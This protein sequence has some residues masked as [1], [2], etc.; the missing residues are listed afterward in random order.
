MGITS[1]AAADRARR[2]DAAP[3]TAVPGD[4]P[5]PR[6]WRLQGLRSRLALFSFL[7]VLVAGGGSAA[8]GWQIVDGLLQSETSDRLELASRTFG[9]LYQQRVSDAEIVTRQLSERTFLSQQILR[10]NS[11]QLTALIDPIHTL[12]P[13]YSITVADREGNV[14]AQI[15]PSSRMAPGPNLLDVPG[16]AAALELDAA[17]PVL[18]R[19]QDCQ[20]VVAVSVPAKTPQGTIVGLMHLRFP[21][22]D[23]FVNQV[24]TDTGLDLSLYCGDM[25]VAT[26]LPGQSTTLGT[27]ADP[28]VVQHVLDEGAEW[29]QNLRIGGHPYRTR[30]VPLLDVEG[31]PVAM[32]AVGIPVQSLQDARNAILRFYLPVMACIAALAMAVG[33]L[34][35]TLLARPLRRLT[36]AA[37]RIGSGDL[38]SPITVA[39]EDEVAQLAERMEE[40][41]RSLFQ[42]Y[43][44]LRQLNQ[45]KDEYLFSVA[46]EVRTPLAS[47]VASVEILAGDYERMSPTERGATIRRIERG[48]VRLQTLVEN[49]LDAGSIRAGRFTILPRAIDLSQVLDGAVASL[50]PLLEDKRQR[51][52]TDIPDDLPAVLADERRIAQVFANLIL[53]ASKYG[54]EGDRITVQGR[55][56]DGFVLVR[57]SDH[58]P[59]IP[60]PEQGELFERYFRAASSARTS[61]GTGLGLA[62]SKAIVEAHEG[63][64][65]LE[66]DPQQG[67]T[68]WFT[69]PVASHRESLDGPSLRSPVSSLAV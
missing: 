54:P 21:L 36:S 61:P 16:V 62:I 1:A 34:G 8:A 65:G 22:D 42:T 64:V 28:Q 11:E 18:V 32:Y 15:A 3:L 63:A 40:M 56:Q 29:E 51:L 10:R 49:V 30:Y 55:V 43:N 35:S 59:G 53:N 4:S 69:L 45:L 39:G 24:K 31:K 37:A 14:L 46:H 9:S 47:L 68:V 13:F 25:L 67:T 38:E 5:A 23:E 20:M 60:L 44:Q 50:Q 27:R 12:R 33:Y 17:L 26:T 48:A 6:P 2:S 66:S 52:E 41:R 19:R 57:V 58:G 7:L